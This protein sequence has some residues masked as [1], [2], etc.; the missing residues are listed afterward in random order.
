VQ[1]ALSAPWS[2]EMPGG[3]P[4]ANQQPLRAHGDDHGFGAGL[5]EDGGLTIRVRLTRQSPPSS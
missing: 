5:A 2:G 1:W 3:G 4:G